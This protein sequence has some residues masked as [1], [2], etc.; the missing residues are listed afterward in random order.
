MYELNVSLCHVF[1]TELLKRDFSDG[2]VAA[3]VYGLQPQV[4]EGAAQTF[5]QALQPIVD[6]G[7]PFTP[8]GRP[9]LAAFAPALRAHCNH[10]I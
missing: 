3:A 9:P 6:E 8:T 5:R 4:D 1:V 10:L 2:A 7:E